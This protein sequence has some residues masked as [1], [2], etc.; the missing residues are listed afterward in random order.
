[1]QCSDRYFYEKNS[2]K[3]EA[4]RNGFDQY[5]PMICID[6]WCQNA[7]NCF[8]PR[9]RQCSGVEMPHRKTHT[10]RGERELDWN[11]GKE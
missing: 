4:S 2:E 11:V 7:L 3:N 6:A 9:L 5:E 10:D 8:F 1:M